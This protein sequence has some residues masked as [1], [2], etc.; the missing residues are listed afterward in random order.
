[1]SDQNLTVGVLSLHSS[2]ESKAILNAVDEMGYGT[3]W[4]RAENTAISVADGEMTLE[5]DVDAVANRLL[6]SSNEHPAE[7]IGLGMTISRLAPMLNEPMAATTALHK[8][9]SAAALADA[10]VPVPDALLALSSDLLNEERDRFGDR[11]VY[12]T[13]IGTHGGGTWMVDLENQVNAQVGGRYAFLQEYMEHDEKRHHDL[14]VYVVG[15]RI[16]G[17]M[18]RYAPEGEWRTNV[19]LGGEVEDMTGEL[20]ERVREIA[21]DS[22]EAIGLDYA[23]VD[24]VQSDDGYYVLEVNPTAGFRGLFKASGVSP[25][26]YIAQ[27]AIERAGG[28]VDDETVERL[29]DRLDDS[30]PACTPKKPQPQAQKNVVVGYIEE[31][32]VTGTQGTKSVLAKSDTG[33][34][35]TSIDAKLAAEIGTGPILDIVKIKSGSVKSGRSRPVVDLVVGVGGTQHTVTA[36]VEDR[37]HMDYPLLLGRDI[38]KHYQVD[39]TRRADDEPEAETEEEEQIEE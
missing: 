33:A 15:D 12:K 35:R 20:P 11:A 27:L 34:T 22:V 1:M 19:A 36:S 38:L 7:G 39:V 30:K 14:R 18:N 31:V 28:S 6:L 21:L 13:A 17:A 9:A 10:G 23:G 8:F 16:V 24:I 4:L 2:K 25:A 29:S 5:P 37:S 3:E 26:P 32:V